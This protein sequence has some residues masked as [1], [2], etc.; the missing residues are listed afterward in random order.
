M[1]DDTAARWQIGACV[2]DAY[3]TLF[4]LRSALTTAAADL[5]AKA[6]P[7]GAL[8]R[9]KQLEYSWLRSLM[10][11]H[12]DFWAVTGEALDYAMAHYG[13]TAPELRARLMSAYLALKAYP[14]ALTVLTALQERRI[15]AAI[16]S[17]G[18]PSMLAA[19]V[20]HA[21]L[22]PLLQEV[23]SVEEVGIFKPHPSVY[24][25]A[26]ERLGVPA[27]QICFLSAN[28]WDIAGAASFGFRAVW[29]NRTGAG[30][31]KLPGKPHAEVK[32]L[33]GLL[34]LLPASAGA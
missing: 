29:V 7:F 2:F 25:L 16:L 13:L 12:A 34:E 27:E 14:D 11:K 1:K 5:G 20:S 23:I 24:Q 33:T 8:W 30:P 6:E 26:V 31:E 18:A 28:G 15:P 32:E 3:G 22:R 17:N 21:G 10:G 9:Q 19:I 4:D